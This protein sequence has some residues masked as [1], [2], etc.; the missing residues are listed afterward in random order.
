M[1][2]VELLAE[3]TR[4][5]EDFRELVETATP[6]ELRHPTDGTKWNNEQ[7]LFHMLFGYLLVRNLRPLVRL[8]SRLPAG[9]S[10]RFAAALNAGTRP[11]HVI[12]YVG[13]LGGARV[14]GRARMIGLM[15]RVTHDLQTAVE[16][17][18]DAELARGMHFPVGWDPYFRDY[19]TFRDVYH[20]ATQHYEHHRRQLTLPRAR[21]T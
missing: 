5:R 15:D 17:A 6:G 16:R 21:D 10:R 14:L 9:V 1:E 3:L 20:Y 19:M 8:L 2:R 7:L 4:T 11:F 13:S 18:T 12:N